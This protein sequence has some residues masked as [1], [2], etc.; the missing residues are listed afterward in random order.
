MSSSPPEAAA[1]APSPQRGEPWGSGFAPH[2]VAPLADALPSPSPATLHRSTVAWLQAAPL[3]AV[4]VVFFL[5]PLA[6]IVMVSFWRPP[7]TS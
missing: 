5:L 6:L 1:G 2:P 3:A 4:F 7:T